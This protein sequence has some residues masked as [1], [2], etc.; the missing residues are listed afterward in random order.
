MQCVIHVDAVPELWSELL[1][2]K[3]SSI[4]MRRFYILKSKR[5]TVNVY[6]GR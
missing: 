3:N 6:L 4:Y 2:R 5:D 1:L